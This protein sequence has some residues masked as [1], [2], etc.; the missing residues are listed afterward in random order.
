MPCCYYWGI[1]HPL[2]P[3]W[4]Q[5]F[6]LVEHKK[7]ICCLKVQRTKWSTK[8]FFCYNSP[9]KNANLN[10]LKSC[11]K[12]VLYWLVFAILYLNS[13]MLVKLDFKGFSCEFFGENE[14]ETGQWTAYKTKGKEVKLQ[15]CQFCD[16]QLKNLISTCSTAISGN[17]RVT[18][19][20]PKSQ[21]PKTLLGH[22]WKML[23]QVMHIIMQGQKVFLWRTY[24]RHWIHVD[25]NL[26]GSLALVI[27]NDHISGLQ[28]VQREAPQ[29][30]SWWNY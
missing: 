3:V 16:L 14:L 11:Y 12:F 26:L 28:F 23:Y 9:Q 19:Q 13:I 5:K 29:H 21:R 7:N 22:I 15:T 30:F 18:N 10:I 24:E 1:S 25:G 17:P 20:R 6:E 27:G 8:D 2:L 4:E